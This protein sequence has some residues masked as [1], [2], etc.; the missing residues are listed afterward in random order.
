MDARLR[1]RR[2][3]LCMSREIQFECVC[4]AH[5]AVIENDPSDST[6]ATID[7]TS[8]SLQVHRCP[9]CDKEHIFGGYIVVKS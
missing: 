5:F 8:K 4:G 6:S 1:G 2:S 3:V 9:R 7:Y